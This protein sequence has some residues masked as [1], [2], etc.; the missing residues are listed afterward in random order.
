MSRQEWPSEVWFYKQA[1]ESFG[2]VSAERLKE[3]LSAGQLQPR[4]AV[5]KRGHE[6]LLFV[7]AAT[8]VFGATCGTSQPPL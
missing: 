2:P 4:Q 5:W 8:A 7:P 6:G 3:L 1:G